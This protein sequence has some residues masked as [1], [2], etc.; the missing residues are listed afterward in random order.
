MCQNWFSI[1]GL[2]LSLVGFL[3]IVLEWTR[4]FSAYA[5]DEIK[6]ISD[7]MRSERKRFGV[8]FAI[9]EDDEDDE[10]NHSMGKHL[11]QGLQDRLGVRMRLVTGGVILTATGTILQIIGALPNLSKFGI[12]A[13]S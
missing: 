11:G 4:A 13:C 12:V 7:F 6:K 3:L 9:D 8:E 1:V 2:T 5:D 10:Y